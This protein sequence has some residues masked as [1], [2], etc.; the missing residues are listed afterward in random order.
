MASF[1]ESALRGVVRRITVE[2]EWLP[3]IVLDDPFASSEGPNPAGALLRPKIAIYTSA[4]EEPFVIAPYGEPRRSNWPYVE[5]AAILAGGVLF[6]LLVNGVFHLI[7]RGSPGRLDGRQGRPSGL[8][9]GTSRVSLDPT[10]WPSSLP[11][12]GGFGMAL[13]HA[14]RRNKKGQF[15]KRKWRKGTHRKVR[16]GHKH[17]GKLAHFGRY[18]WK[19]TCKGRVRSFHLKKK[20]ATRARPAGCRISRC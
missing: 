18:K 13:G 15:L 7:D 16:H 20:A 12:T 9:P 14:P 4:D 3:P 8:S 2:T 11:A 19:V 1:L 10:G 6:A 17:T 5:V